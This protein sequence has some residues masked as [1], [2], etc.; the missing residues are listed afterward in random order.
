MRLKFTKKLEE[1]NL[2][3]NNLLNSLICYNKFYI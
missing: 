3:A 2:T 1:K